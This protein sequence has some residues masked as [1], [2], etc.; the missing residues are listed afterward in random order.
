MKNKT[1]LEKFLEDFENDGLGVFN[2]GED[3]DLRII[4]RMKELIAEEKAELK[5]QDDLKRMGADKPK[6]THDEQDNMDKLEKAELSLAELADEKGFGRIQ[7]N[8]FRGNWFITIKTYGFEVIESFKAKTY[9]EA[10]QK[11]KLYLEGLK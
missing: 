3:R 5:I 2:F 10:E 6:I 9:A 8:E 7:I 1:G 4:S 11:A